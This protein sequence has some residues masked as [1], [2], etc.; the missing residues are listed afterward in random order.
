MDQLKAELEDICPGVVS[1]ADLIALM[2]RDSLQAV[3]FEN[4]VPQSLTLIPLNLRASVRLCSRVWSE[5]E[6]WFKKIVYKER[7]LFFFTDIRCSVYTS[8]LYARVMRG[9]VLSSESYHKIKSAVSDSNASRPCRLGVPLIEFFWVG[10]MG[11]YRWKMKPIL[12][13]RLFKII[14]HSYIPSHLSGSTQRR[15]RCFPVRDV[16]DSRKQIHWNLL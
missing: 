7:R 4:S 5:T 13:R 11:W 12:F 2:A 16:Y 15:W 6:Q 1:C 8:S 14:Q 3:S 9:L 10:E